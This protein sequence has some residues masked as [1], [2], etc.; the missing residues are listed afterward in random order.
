MVHSLISPIIICILVAIAVGVVIG[1]VALLGAI[2]VLFFIYRYRKRKASLH[3]NSEPHKREENELR[4]VDKKPLQSQQ[5]SIPLIPSSRNSNNNN[6]NEAKVP[7]PQYRVLHNIKVK[8]VLGEG[9]FGK[10]YEGS[11][12]GT[13]VRGPDNNQ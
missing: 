5:S 1:I 10:V 11:W 12:D 4:E 3:S 9:N 8:R 7:S 2:I 6:N 13:P